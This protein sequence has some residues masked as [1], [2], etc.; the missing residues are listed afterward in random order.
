MLKPLNYKLP[1]ERIAQ[2]PLYPYDS[3][4]MLCVDKATG[5]IQ[6]RTFQD[7]SEFVQP[8]DLVVFNDT[9]VIPA[10]L[11]GKFKDSG[12]VVE[13]LLLQESSS[14]IWEILAR[15]AKK[16]KVGRVIDFE[17]GLLGEVITLDPL[18][19]RF[20]TEAG[21][22]TKELLSQVGTM[23]IPPYIRRGISDERDIEDYQTH[24]A[25]NEGS[26]AAPTAS[27][28]FTPSV[29]EKIKTVTPIKP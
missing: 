27:L 25:C 15:P 4:K 23:P 5:I 3:A 12:G 29:V 14:D 11:F 13:I 8:N 16:L 21:I 18:S 10:R 22:Q 20:S 6:D 2:R 26:V 17:H 1:Q 24:F 7:F 9:K 28:H 19:I